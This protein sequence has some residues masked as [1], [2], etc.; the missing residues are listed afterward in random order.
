MSIFKSLVAK[1]IHWN[2]LRDYANAQEKHWKDG[3]YH[4]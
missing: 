2:W 4:G 3:K 1:L